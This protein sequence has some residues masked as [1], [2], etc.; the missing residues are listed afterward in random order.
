VPSNVLVNATGLA[1]RMGMVAE[2]GTAAAPDPASALE[3][4]VTLCGAAMLELVAVGAASVFKIAVVL[5]IA[6]FSFH[7][8]RLRT[9]KSDSRIASRISFWA[10]R[11]AWMAW[12]SP[13]MRVK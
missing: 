9:N 13:D 5:E 3:A 12:L 10:G 7:V 4:A 2:L 11:E 8:F 1:L 6:A